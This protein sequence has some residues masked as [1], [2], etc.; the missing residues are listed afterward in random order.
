MRG[1]PPDYVYR[2]EAIVTKRRDGISMSSSSQPSLMGLMLTRLDLGPGQ[3]VLEIGAGTG[4]NAAL[5]A[6]LVGPSGS[7]T[8]VDI[9]SE[10]A[11][12]AR[13]NL[14]HAG[15]PHVNVIA[16][17][18]GHGV[19]EAGLFDR[20]IVTAGCWQISPAWIE[21]LAPDGSIVLPLRING[22]SLAP[23]FR[24]QGSR[25]VASGAD[26]CGF[27]QLEGAFAG[28]YRSEIGEGVMAA[29]DHVLTAEERSTI[30][31]LLAASEPSA[32]KLPAFEDNPELALSFLAFLGLQGHPLL[33]LLDR[34]QA[35]PKGSQLLLVS[36]D[37]ALSLGVS[38][39][40]HGTREA[41]TFVREALD[42]WA[43]AGRPTLDRICLR[44]DPES[45]AGPD[46]PE[47]HGHRYGFRRG[48]HAI[49]LWFE[50]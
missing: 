5:L 23:F 14:R 37:S 1:F 8:T 25:L 44:V 6:D 42:D 24:R 7:V 33:A 19:P 47:A 39:T 15:Y 22:L 18:G 20:I 27:I 32:L 38:P 29:S 45:A 4:Y 35:E 26:P 9:D 17:D 30:V 34:R 31:R 2:D 41:E 16:R 11:A 10:V 50:P 36:P 46:I 43:Q 28:G 40:V 13:Q 49:E 48:A 3:R 12:I 21:Q